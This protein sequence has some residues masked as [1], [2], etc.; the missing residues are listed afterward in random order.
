[1]LP[2]PAR[3]SCIESAFTNKGLTIL[4]PVPLGARTF[5]TPPSIGLKDTSC[6]GDAPRPLR[7]SNLSIYG[8]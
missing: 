2:G 8:N 3:S 6:G 4:H 1:M 5:S 7:N